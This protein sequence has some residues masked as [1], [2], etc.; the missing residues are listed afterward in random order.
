MNG[1]YISPFGC[2]SQFDRYNQD[3]ELTEFENIALDYIKSAF[4]AAD[5]NFEEL[6]FRRRS[7]NYLT[8]LSPNDNDFCRL[9]VSERSVWYSITGAYLPSDLKNDPRFDGVK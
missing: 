3:A 6:R 5:L 7:D 1:V 9:K 8:I 4:S 2:G